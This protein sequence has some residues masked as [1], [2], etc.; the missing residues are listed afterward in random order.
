MRL[1]STYYAL[2]SHVL[3]AKMAFGQTFV[4]WNS[5][6]DIHINEGI[7]FVVKDGDFVNNSGHLHNN[8]RLTVHGDF[9]LNDSVES[10]NLLAV[11]PQY[12]VEGTWNNNSSFIAGNSRTSLFGGN[13]QI[14]G[15]EVTSYYDLDLT[16]NGIKELDGVDTRILHELNLTA[17]ELATK[18]Q[19]AYVD[20]DAEDAILYI[21]DSG[22]VSSTGNGRLVRKTST[23]LTYIYPLGQQDLQTIYYR[24]LLIS[25]DNDNSV[26]C[27]LAYVNAGLEGKPL[28]QKALDIEDLNSQFFHL[29]E[30]SDGSDVSGSLAIAYEITTEGEWVDIGQWVTTSSTQDQWEKTFDGG[31]FTLDGLEA[32]ATNSWMYN[33]NPAHILLKVFEDIDY[34][35]PTA[36]DPQSPLPENQ[37]FTVIDYFGTID[38]QRLQVFNRWG[39][40][41][42][43][44]QRDGGDAWD[45]TFRGE[46]QQSGNYVYLATLIDITGRQIGPLNGNVI[47]VR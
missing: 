40:M 37:N 28:T 47:L 27:R 42:Y 24:P 10:T 35:F 23:G 5:G 11:Q 6:Q 18:E 43:D 15:S 29:I 3:I 21:L 25:T 31:D 19:K 7:Q 41:V 20:S 17:N 9:I 1:Y 39:T 26:E 32:I 44:S 14:T 38:I 2:L 36:F 8:G 30:S 46:L 45:G 12:Q 16:G 34:D 4:V 22:F 13:Q 33:G